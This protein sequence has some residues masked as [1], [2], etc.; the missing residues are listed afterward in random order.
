MLYMFQAVPP[1]IIRISKLYTHSI[2]YMS[3]LLAAT[4]TVAAS[5]LDIYQ[6]LC[7]YSFRD[8]DYGWRKRLK[9]VEH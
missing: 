8:H 6:M 1:P 2:R 9:H 3:S 7:V 4:L 5:K